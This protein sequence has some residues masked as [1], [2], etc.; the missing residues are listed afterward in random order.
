MGFPPRSTLLTAGSDE[1]CTCLGRLY[2]FPAPAISSRASDPPQALARG[3]EREAVLPVTSHLS[4]VPITV[5][6]YISLAG[7]LSVSLTQHTQTGTRAHR[8]TVTL[9]PGI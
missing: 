2:F 9:G 7:A 6:P 4:L 8:H 3:R 1:S 5:P